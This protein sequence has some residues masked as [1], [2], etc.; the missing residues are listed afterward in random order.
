MS[1][2]CRR[3][4]FPQIVFPHPILSFSYLNCLLSPEGRRLNTTFFLCYFA[5]L[6]P[7]CL[8]NH[9]VVRLMNSNQMWQSISGVSLS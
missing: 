2:N 1:Q 9:Y 8:F 6:L 4:F 3:S 5:K 7:V